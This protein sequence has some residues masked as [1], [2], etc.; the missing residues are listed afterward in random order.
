[1]NI[2]SQLWSSRIQHWNWRKISYKRKKC[3]WNN[4][5]V[6]TVFITDRLSQNYFQKN[7]FHPSTW[8]CGVMF[9]KFSFGLK[10]Y[11]GG[12]SIQIAS[13]LNSGEWPYML[14]QRTI[15]NSVT[16]LQTL[17]K[18]NPCLMTSLTLEYCMKDIY[19]GDG[20]A[21]IILIVWYNFVFR[22]QCKCL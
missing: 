10:N 20:W 11:S 1:M 2:W 21:K 17:L 7:Y 18:V 9:L 16:I 14:S 22:N 3:F 4:I 6:T 19:Q 5:F 12:S 8:T 13:K 15:S